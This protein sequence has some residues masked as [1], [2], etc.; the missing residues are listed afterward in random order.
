MEYTY[1]F[2]E[3]KN[4]IFIRPTDEGYEIQLRYNV[5]DYDTF[6]G[7][8]LP[9][10][11]TKEFLSVVSKSKN[12]IMSFYD[13]STN[14]EFQIG[15]EI[16]SEI[17]IFFEIIDYNYDGANLQDVYKMSIQR[18]S[19]DFEILDELIKFLNITLKK[20]CE[21]DESEFNPPEYEG[22]IGL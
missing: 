3:N 11:K 14:L 16:N 8:T 7:V 18:T 17:A 4:K 21:N 2:G 20:E 6:V 15:Y 5:D 19:L 12:E 9:V 22:K 13:K 1:C 10:E